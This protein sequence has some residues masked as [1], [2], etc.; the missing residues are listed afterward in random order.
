MADMLT[1]NVPGNFDL[2]ILASRLRDSFQAQGFAVSV[3]MFSPNSAK[4]TFDKNCGGLNMV[5][6]MGLGITANMT[7]N[8]N[9][10]C[11]N[12][13]DGDWI[14]KIIGIAVGW[15]LCFVPFITAIIGSINQSGFPKKIN[16]E[17]TM[18]AS[19][20]SGMNGMNG[21]NGMQNR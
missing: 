11:V 15:I 7:L 5:M 12:Y 9:L 3:A 13:S 6:G 4:V 21:M 1:I 19:S 2:N 8:G 10:L 14:G 18:I 17:I 16:T 20:M